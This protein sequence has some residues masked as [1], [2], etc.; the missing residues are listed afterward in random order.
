MRR[1]QPDLSLRRHGGAERQKAA[2]FDDLIL[3][4]SQQCVEELVQI[5]MSH[6]RRFLHF[7]ALKAFRISRKSGLEKRSSPGLT[8]S[9]PL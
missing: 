2:V 1:S 3:R 9:T 7:I 8:R 5:G 4:E 6:G